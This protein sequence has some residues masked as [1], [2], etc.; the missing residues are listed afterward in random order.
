MSLRY[1]MLVI[2]LAAAGTAG[3]Q[4]PSPKP[5]AKAVVKA[6]DEKEPVTVDAER[7]DG[8][9]QLEVTARGR[10]EINQGD[11]TIFGDYLK[12]NQEFGRVD[13]D[14]GVRLQMGVDR[15]FGPRL[16]Y[17]TLDDTGLLEEPKFSMQRDLP[18]H[19]SAESVE[20]LARQKY[21]LKG[22]SYTTCQPGHEDWT[23]E[24]EELELDYEADKGNAHWPKLRFFDTTILASPYASFPL[25]NQRKSGLLSPYY[26]HSSTRGIEVGISYY[27]NIAPERDYTLTPVFMTKRGTLFKNDFRYIDRS[28][29][30]QLR[31]E[32]MP[33]DEELQRDRGGVS[34]QHTQTITP[35]LVTAIDYNR[36]SDDR[37]FVDLSSQVRTVS[38]GNLQQDAYA[39]YSN[40]LN[41]Y[42]YS[43]QTRVQRFQTLQD[44]LAP[45]VPPY[46]RVPQLNFT[47]S[48]NDLG[49]FLDTGFTAE[50]VRFLHPTLVQGSR[51]SANPTF[52]T[53]VL[54]PGWFFTPKAGLRYAGYSIENTPVGT[55]NNPAVTI[56]WASLDTG[57]VFER[58]TTWFG[59]ALSQTL[60][61]R[62]YYVYVPFRNQDQ[63]PVFDTALADFNFAQLFSENRFTGGDRFGDAN[64]LT[65]AVTTRILQQGGQERFRAT[66]GQRYYFSDERV[67]LTPTSTLRT[68]NTS[69]YLASIGGRATKAT[70]FDLTTQYNQ[71]EDRFERYSVS[72]RYNPELA[73]VVNASYRF[74]ADPL[75]PIR[76]VDISGQWPFARG[77]YAVGRYNYSL[78]DHRIVDGVAAIEYNAGC[79]VFR[80]AIQRLQAAAQI[81]STSIFFQLEFTGVGQL[82]TDEIVTLLK[83]S[84]PGYAVTNPTD[85]TLSPPALRQRLPFEQTY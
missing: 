49:G 2:A 70:A 10:A 80:G 75:N 66:L 82:G 28:Y 33:G 31:L 26:A 27:W 54:N 17:S 18:A 6:A 53:P 5:A 29:A 36:V 43:F 39:V 13:G 21:R 51:I 81:A 35:H 40:T 37:Y 4:A 77:W 56:P 74:N 1:A 72:A 16:R 79:W 73:K 44:P 48:A 58:P 50:Y 64:Q 30:G 11:L 47:T 38:I 83:R 42:P 12:Y 78:L 15:F 57:L 61:P 67:S 63:I 62:L 84:V 59:D 8:I 68:Y 7:I 23:V 65:F 71:R 46:A 52:A 69:D 20:F 60:E 76:Q 9:G 41:G 32:Y 19:G 85:P 55:S 45:I 25:D 24:A 3:A 34:F 22:A 14:G